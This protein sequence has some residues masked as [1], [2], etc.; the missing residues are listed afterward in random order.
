[1]SG[2]LSQGC[3][4]TAIAVIPVLPLFCYYFSGP[5][6]PNQARAAGYVSSR[7]TCGREDF[8][9]DRGNTFSPTIV[10]W[11]RFSIQNRAVAKIFIVRPRRFLARGSCSGKGFYRA[12]AKVFRPEF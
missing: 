6:R 7:E 11:Q 2:S 10:Q 8:L 5:G 12:V 1:M 4:N 3:G 9:R